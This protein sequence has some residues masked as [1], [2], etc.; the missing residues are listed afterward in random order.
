VDIIMADS[1]SDLD[2]QLNSGTSFAAPAITGSIN[3][4]NQ[5]RNSLHPN[6]RPWLASTMKGLVIH[7]T[8]ESGSSPGP[9]Y[10]FGWGLMNTRKAAELIRNNA[11]NG[12]KSFIKEVFIQNGG[13]IEFPVPFS[14]GQTGRFTIVWTDLAG[15]SQ[16][17]TVDPTTARLVNDLD[18][19]VISPSGVTNFPYVLNPDLTN[20][21]STVRAAAATTGDDT[22]NNVEQVVITNT[23]AGNY[24]VRVSHKGSL[25]T[26]G[27]WVSFDLSGHQAQSK[28][29][30]TISQPVL[31]S[32]NKL[33]FAWPSIVG[34]LYR[35]QSRDG[36]ETGSWSNLTG[37]ISATKTNTAVEVDRNSTTGRRFYRIVE[38]E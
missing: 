29:A 31:V 35:V 28:P 24:L 14:S 8:D 4:L 36:L 6:A 27:Q 34:Q 33:A 25:G 3:L 13:S 38:I 15:V 1:D 30:L 7:T 16:T 22:R 19:R 12:W 11:T 37:E 5:L 20:Q 9:D 10:Q 23:A 17:N 2:F 21:N 32:S 26:N 18:L